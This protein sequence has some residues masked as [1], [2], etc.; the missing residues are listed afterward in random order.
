MKNYRL[1]P[2]L[3]V[4]GP[5][6]Q[7]TKTGVNFMFF[8]LIVVESCQ[9]YDAIHDYFQFGSEPVLINRQRLHI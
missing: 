4:L 7:I 2:V 9:S 8:I 5:K 3:F 6:A 1:K